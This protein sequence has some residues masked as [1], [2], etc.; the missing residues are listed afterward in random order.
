MGSKTLQDSQ[1][2]S[3]PLVVSLT[4]M[5]DITG[6][7]LGIMLFLAIWAYRKDE[8][9]KK[10]LE[11]V[12]E[13]DAETNVRLISPLWSLHAALSHLVSGRERVLLPGGTN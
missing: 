9:D 13:L 3:P 10:V 7:M 11:A 4:Y 2:A 1:G 8:H 12:E 6:T 5:Y